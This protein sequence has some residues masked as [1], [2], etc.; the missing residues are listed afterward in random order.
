M[1]TGRTSPSEPA[2]TQALPSGGHS[3]DLS[4]QGLTW[5]NLSVNIGV[6]PSGRTRRGAESFELGSYVTTQVAEAHA[7]LTA[8]TPDLSAPSWERWHARVL[9]VARIRVNMAALG[10]K[11][12]VKAT[13]SLKTKHRFQPM[14]SQRSDLPITKNL[15]GGVARACPPRCSD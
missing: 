3:L 13:M 10:Q 9:R 5:L 1:A 15:V 11:M 2:P 6:V 8:E 7:R 14:E 12:K 4:P